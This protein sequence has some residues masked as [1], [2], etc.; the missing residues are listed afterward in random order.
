MKTSLKHT[1]MVLLTLMLCAPAAAAAQVAIVGGEVHTVSGDVIEDGAVVI[2]AEG[3]IAAV[4]A[5]G[6]VAIP[7]GVTVVDA[8]G[9]VVTPGFVD[10]SS[11]LG[12]VE[13]EAVRSGRDTSSG[14]GPIRAAFEA[15][16]SFN[17]RSA[18]IPVQRTGGVTDVVIVPSGGLIQGRASW[19]ELAGSVLSHAT[20]VRRG[21]AMLLQLGDG[22]SRHTG[23]SRGATAL[24]LKRIYEDV[25]FFAKSPKAFDDN[26]SRKLVA[27]RLDLLALGNTL[28]GKQAVMV[29]ADR[30]SDISFALQFAKAQGLKIMISGGSE[31][32]M[33]ADELAA[34]RVA[35]MVNPLNNLPRSMSALGSRADN[36]AL[37]AKAGVPVIIATFETH[38][39]RKLP[40][41]AGNAV[42]AGLPHAAALDA[43]TRQPAVAFGMGATH[44]TLEPGKVG[45]VVV[46]S[47]DPFELSTRVDAMFVR[48]K[49][50]D[51]QA[52]RQRMLLERYRTLERRGPPAPQTAGVE[53]DEAE[54]DT[55]EAKASDE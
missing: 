41:V 6:A 24:M 7:A 44:G 25:R 40:Q 5:R 27:N 38:N 9:K 20:V 52:N 55:P 23:G 22:A 1:L 53:A 42:R 43:V 21:V 30:A 50:V 14:E 35:V 31:A 3:N 32:W 39:V 46:W 12:M 15:A 29:R 2:D 34:A 49:S 33:V 45:N 10:T 11:R 16:D 19:V 26:R 18:V 17:P 4:G 54:S 36:A 51:P 37:L 28:D 48:G 8:T 47:G 13:I